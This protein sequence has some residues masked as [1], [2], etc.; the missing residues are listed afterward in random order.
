MIRRCRLWQLNLNKRINVPTQRLT[1]RRAPTP[2]VAGDML[3]LFLVA[4]AAA[5]GQ[6]A[7]RHLSEINDVPTIMNV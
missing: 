5:R 2:R 6:A 4:L 1:P 7:P 3:K